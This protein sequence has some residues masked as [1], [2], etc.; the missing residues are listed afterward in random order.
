MKK[1]AT[2]HLL[3]FNIHPKVPCGRTSV[4][5][6]SGDIQDVT[7]KKCKRTKIFKNST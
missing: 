1:M 5:C 7:C 4:G 6:S 2:V 3:K